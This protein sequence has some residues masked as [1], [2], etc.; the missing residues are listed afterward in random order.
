[1]E[2]DEDIGLDG[3]AHITMDLPDGSDYEQAKEVA[4]FLNENL[5]AF[6]IS[7]P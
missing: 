4:R 6:R 5:A 1:M 2:P 3:A 7:R